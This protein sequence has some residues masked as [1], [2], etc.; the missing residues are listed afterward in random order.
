M[1]EVIICKGWME[2]RHKEK[3]PV[4]QFLVRVALAV[5]RRQDIVLSDA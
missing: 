4:T 2:T 5:S 1:G 3:V